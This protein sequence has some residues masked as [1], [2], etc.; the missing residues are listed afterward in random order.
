MRSK[1]VRAQLIIFAIIS[2]LAVGYGA[3]AYA[4]FQR[5]TGIG[6]YTVTAELS[7]AGGLY[8]NALV[9]YRGVDVGVVTGIDPSSAGAS[10]KLQ[11]KSDFKIPATSEAYVRSVSAAGEQFIDLV[12]T[13]GDQGGMLADGSQIPQSRTN[14]PIPATD[15]I[16]KVQNLLAK[17]PK[18]DLSITVNEASTALQGVGPDLNSALKSSSELVALAL[19]NLEQTTT[20]LV[21]ADPLLTTVVNSGTNI[22]AFSSNLASFT[23][24]LSLSDNQIRTVLDSGPSAVDSV[25]GLFTDMRRPLPV[26]LANLQSVGEV[27]RVNV[28]GI[29]HL[30]VV[31]PAIATAVNSDGRE[32]SPGPNDKESG[33]AALDLKLGNTNNPPPCT[34]GYTAQ[35]RN[36]GDLSRAPVTDTSYCELPKADPRVARGARNLPC[37]TDPSV[38]TGD[39][40]KCPDGLP[41]TWPS[42]LSKPGNHYTVGDDPNATPEAVPYDPATGRFQVSTGATYTLGSLVNGSGATTKEKSSWQQLFLH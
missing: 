1:L 19:T 34:Y 32:F 3:Y 42:L 27:L 39:V 33:Q 26:L 40:A 30:L 35:R 14:I 6:T 18:K 21:D 8:P 31:Y 11:I 38:R 28:P 13:N 17:V 7:N 15:V 29:R 41:S 12:P 4:G 36:P 2:I 25:S 16:N 10:A 37:A 5:Y 22:S 9:T 24:Q 23:T 20:L